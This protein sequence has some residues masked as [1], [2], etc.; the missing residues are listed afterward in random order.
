MDPITRRTAQETTQP[1]ATTPTTPTPT[2]TSA[3]SLVIE[4][5]HLEDHCLYDID[6]LLATLTAAG[7]AWLREYAR[8]NDLDWDAQGTSDLDLLCDRLAEAGM[9]GD[10][11]AL[12]GQLH[13]SGCS[14]SLFAHDE[15]THELGLALSARLADD[16][17]YY[18]FVNDE[19]DPR[20][21]FERSNASFD[22]LQAQARLVG[23]TIGALDELN[24]VRATF[25]AAT[26]EHVGRNGFS[27]AGEKPTPA[28]GIHRAERRDITL[29]TEHGWGTQVRL[30]HLD[31]ARAR[32]AA[33]WGHTDG[34]FDLVSGHPVAR[35]AH[36]PGDL[37]AL[38]LLLID[39]EINI[40]ETS[41]SDLP[42]GARPPQSYW[43][44]NDN[45]AH[46]NSSEA[47]GT[48]A[49]CGLLDHTEL[50]DTFAQLLAAADYGT[51]T[52]AGILALTAAVL[53]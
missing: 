27:E 18:V 29:W 24:H 32:L 2:A 39:S 31:A 19:A 14:C 16:E 4:H 47:L 38:L 28:Y 51:D 34:S 23:R 45:F 17:Y 6:D 52:F 26:D 15:F 21:R 35:V 40:D 7:S 37:V 1:P 22:Q 43:D 20:G 48:L 11:A 9:P 25:A 49:V 46:L 30:V 50:R 3:A 5:D 33:H 12:R 8:G 10:A 41:N 36:L 13:L 42:Y 53:T 44:R